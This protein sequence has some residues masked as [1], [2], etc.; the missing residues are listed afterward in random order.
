MTV[1][2]A[3]RIAPVSE[4]NDEQRELLVKSTVA[5]ST[6]PPNLFA[7]LVA[8]PRLMGRVNALGGMFMVHGTI[9]ARD[10]ELMI[11]RAATLIECDYELQQHRRLAAAAGLTEDEMRA[12]GSRLVTVTGRDRA[13]IELV[14]EVVVRHDVTDPTWE[15]VRTVTEWTDAQLLEVLVMIGFYA[16]LGGVLNACGIPLDEIGDAAGEEER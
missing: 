11:L 15:R 14:D 10:R 2:G 3:P 1:P 13:L 5:T 9:S 12:V 6:R 16:M 8:H 4:P 7:T